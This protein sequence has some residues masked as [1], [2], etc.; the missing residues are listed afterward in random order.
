MRAG[1]FHIASILLPCC[2]H[3][4]PSA[5]IDGAA[6]LPLL[7]AQVGRVSFPMKRDHER[8]KR[9]WTS[10]ARPSKKSLKKPG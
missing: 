4:S 10:S 1:G 7:T 5:G 8:I 2:L 9:D 6:S 3:R